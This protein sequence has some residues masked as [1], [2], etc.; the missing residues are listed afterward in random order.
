MD[1]ENVPEAVGKHQSYDVRIYLI[2][3]AIRPEKHNLRD[4]NYHGALYYSWSCTWRDRRNVDEKP[5][6][7]NDIGKV[8]VV[9]YI[10]RHKV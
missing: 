5:E 7:F 2:A 8:N 3:F 1:D 10:V 4:I 6:W 9:F